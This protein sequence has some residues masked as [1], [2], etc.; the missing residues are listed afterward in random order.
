MSAPEQ[1][2]SRVVADTARAAA[3]AS[4]LDRQRRRLCGW[5]RTS[6]S[7][8]VVIAPRG[9]E[10]VREAVLTAGRHGGL[11]ARGAGRSYGDAAQNGGGLV[12]DL[13]EISQIELLPGPLLRVG[14]GASLSQVLR[15]LAGSRLTLPVVP[16]TRHITVGGAIAADI[17]G[18]NHR[19]D[20]SFGHHVL[21]MTL[22]TPDGVLREISREIEPDLF[23]ATLGGMGLTGVIVQ[24]RI[25]PGTLGAPLL[26]GDIDRVGSIEQALAV[27]REDAAHRYSIA[28]VDLLS[29]G[30]AFGRSVVLR[31]S[32]R[33]LPAGDR[34]LGDGVDA[35]VRLP[36]RPRLVVP[37]RCPAGLLRP[38][39]VRTFNTLRWRR[40]PLR[41]R[42]RPITAGENFFPLDALGD[43]NRLYGRAG[44]VQYQFAVPEERS[45]SLLE[46]VQHLRRARQPIYLAVIKR[47]G[48]PSGGML[49]FPAP[50]W[51]LAIDLPA[52]S[53][54]LRPALDEADALVAHAGGRVY[55]AKDARLSAGMLGTMYPQ[56]A[57]FIEIRAQVDPHCTLRSDMARR[58][59]LGSGAAA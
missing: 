44:L 33:P 18:K 25:V 29:P 47:F 53:R 24:A 15:A 41:A 55:L 9:V 45:A 48:A 17:H 21:G 58:L 50:G 43:W 16:G 19:R 35:R 38:A 40:A 7:E 23:H 20:G 11:I 52:A 8:A 10:Q 22:C 3:R 26:D 27:M 39:T 2:V 51:T 56:L 30:N 5:G 42:R 59:G 32:E 13:A 31:S 37:E 4:T 6:H 14:A 57:R 1:T 12:L 54:G 34:D 49:S 46:V 28:W 36:G